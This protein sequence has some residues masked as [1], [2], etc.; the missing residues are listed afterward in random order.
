MLQMPDG[1]RTSHFDHLRKGQ[2][3]ISGPVFNQAIACYL[4]LKSFGM[5]DLDFTPIFNWNSIGWTNKILP[6]L[7]NPL[8]F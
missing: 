8:L 3:A 4:K 7:S 6:N 2:V 5:Q 1:T